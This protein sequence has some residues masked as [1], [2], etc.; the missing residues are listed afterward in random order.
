M[1]PAQCKLVGARVPSHFKTWANIKD[2][3]EVR[4]QG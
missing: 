1:M 3:F 4:V 2:V